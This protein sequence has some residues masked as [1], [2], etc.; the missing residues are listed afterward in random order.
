MC[1][2]ITV[3]VRPPSP[4][5]VCLS[6]RTHEKTL[7]GYFEFPK[8][9]VVCGRVPWLYQYWPGGFILFVVLC[10]GTPEG[11]TGSGSGL[12]ESQK[13]GQRLKASS[14]ILGEAGNQTCDPW[15]TTVWSRIVFYPEFGVPIRRWE[16]GPDRTLFR[17]AGSEK[18]PSPT[19]VRQVGS[20]EKGPGLTLVCQVRSKEWAIPWFGRFGVQRKDRA[21]RW[22]GVRVRSSEKGPGPIL[23]RQVRSSEKGPGLT[24][25]CQVRSKY[26]PN[27]GSAGSE[28][29]ER[30]GPNPVSAGS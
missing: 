3:R 24:L 27:P 17:S 30:N 10:P 9:L 22:F 8:I 1:T 20:S 18:G 7:V 5:A 28:F 21:E 26:A 14:D 6:V 23:V 15:F 29:G 19:L 25:V 13:T 2:I 11:T 4:P 12:K 16:K